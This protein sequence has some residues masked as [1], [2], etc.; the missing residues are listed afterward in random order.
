M[1]QFYASLESGHT[2]T[3]AALKQLASCTARNRFYRANR[4]LDRV[5]KTAFLLGSLSEPQ[6]RACIRRGL[7]KVE[8]CGNDSPTRS[9][10]VTGWAGRIHSNDEVS[11]RR[12]TCTV[13]ARISVTTSP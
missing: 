13:H 1:R 2:T 9:G 5:F 6:L 10:T 3:S 11:S 4:D 7:L 12:A 8:Q